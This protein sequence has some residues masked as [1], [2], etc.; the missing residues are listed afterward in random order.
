MNKLSNTARAQVIA[1]L[2][3][4]TSINATVRMTGVTKPTILKLIADL[5]TACQ[6][7]HDDRVRGLTTARVQ[8]DEIWAFCHCKAKNV[9]PEN[10]GVLGYGDIWTFTGIDADS[11]LMIAWSVGFR[12]ATWANNFMLDC[13]DPSACMSS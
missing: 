4:G 6:R 8:C 2:V 5:G 12:E 7:F 11:K 10:R 3:E 13:S 9:A 1:A